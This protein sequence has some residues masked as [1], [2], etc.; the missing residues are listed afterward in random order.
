[1]VIRQLTME[2]FETGLALDEYAFHFKLSE[3]DKVRE[4][5]R[6]KPER[7]WGFYEDGELGAQ[8]TLLPLS[9]YIQG[10]VVPMGGIAGVSTWPENRR[11]GMVAKLLTHVLG[12]MNDAGQKISMLHPFLIPF[13]RRFGWEVYCEHKEY[14]LSA[15]Q[16]PVRQ[17][18]QGTV[19]RDRA[20]AEELEPLYHAFASGY[21]GTLMRERDWWENLLQQEDRHSAVFYSDSGEPQGYILYKIGNRE[22]TV[23]E[24]VYLNETARQGLWA[25]I[26]NHEATVDQ[27]KLTRVPADDLLPFLLPDPRIKQH[28]HPYFMAR[29]VNA[30]AFVNDYS[31]VK[32]AEPGEAVI[33]IEDEHAP[34]NNGLWK[35]AVDEQGQG[36]LA[37]AL[38]QDNLEADLRCGIG[39]LTA[40]LL[41]YKRPAELARSGILTGK[42]QSLQWLEARVPAA[43]TALFDFF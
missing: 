43:Q 18:I 9:L 32:S 5:Q 36:S 37:A 20:T 2:E 35:L 6:Y 21:N 19:K 13:Y 16:Y 28:S 22:L 34:W 41:G 1:M 40:M 14:V 15:K 12:T 33:Y 17:E 11:Q 29:L 24:F 38:D 30:Q 4:K 23:E 25:F 7:N 42:E 27:V 26:R 10:K 31:F 3:E 8:L 39:V